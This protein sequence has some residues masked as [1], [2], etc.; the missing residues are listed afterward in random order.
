VE[1]WLISVDNL[2]HLWITRLTAHGALARYGV[3]FK[4]AANIWQS[5]IVDNW[6]I[7]VEKQLFLGITNK[8]ST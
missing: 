3:R 7:T 2:L 5:D 6:L 8:N 4:A 1:K